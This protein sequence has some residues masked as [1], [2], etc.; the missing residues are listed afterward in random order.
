MKTIFY[1]DNYRGFSKQFIELGAVN[2]FVGE[3][4][5]GKTSIVSLLTL[6]SNPKFW[7]TFE[8]DD[9]GI[10]LGAYED[11]FS[12]KHDSNHFT[13]GFYS[14]L[15][16]KKK[17]DYM[18]LLKF[19]NR[20]GMP[21]VCEEYILENDT[22]LS[23]RHNTKTAVYKVTKMTSCEECATSFSTCIEFIT[24]MNFVDGK[25]ISKKEGSNDILTYLSLIH[26]KDPE[27][28]EQFSNFIPIS[29]METRGISLVA[30]IRAKPKNIYT[31]NKISYDVE[32]EYAPYII[33][34]LFK[35]KAQKKIDK[36]TQE[37]INYLFEFGKESGLFD[38]IS[39][40]Q[41]S[42]KSNS[43]FEI[44]ILKSNGKYKINNVG[45]GVSQVL[46]VLTST[47]GVAPGNWVSIQQPEVHLH[48]RAQAAFGELVFI[49][50]TGLKRKFIIETHSDYVIDRFRYKLKNSDEKLDARVMFFENV[51]GINKIV[52][53]NIQKNGSYPTNQPDG[54]RKF[55]IDE[56]MNLLGI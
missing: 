22:L 52:S 44:D 47:L 6:I 5:S 33:K 53:M 29:Y 26:Q 38:N 32:G 51:E 24:N 2:F 10:D 46:P 9:E 31:G 23:I 19:K 14:K 1:V 40:E 41:F 30:P 12:Y 48:P 56:T 35:I 4:S 55:F 13:I 18:H 42:K 34:G 7:Y 27:I 37:Q 17:T 43:P 16:S 45:Y 21:A 20:D 54:F 50:A 28:K 49:A 39:V 36:E 3:N 15:N 11:I 25:R 8:F